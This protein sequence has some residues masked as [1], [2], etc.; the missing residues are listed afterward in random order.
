MSPALSLIAAAALQAAPVAAPVPAAPCD[1]PVMLVVS[2]DHLD[3]AK[4][5][6]YAEAL[7]DSGIVKRNGGRY[8]VVGA[9]A[10]LLEGTWPSDRGFVIEQYPCIEA[11]RA[12]WYSDDYQRRIKPLRAGSGDY[13]IALFNTV[14]E[15]VP[16]P[17]PVPR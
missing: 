14:G 2:V 3:R 13:T 4:S 6:P 16:M 5:K 9:P 8:R 12:M 15:P 1:K 7:R 11:F 10:L 17:A